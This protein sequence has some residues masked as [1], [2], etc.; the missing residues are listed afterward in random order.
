MKPALNFMI[1]VEADAL[2]A[3]LQRI[4]PRWSR[5]LDFLA[6]LNL[7][8]RSNVSGF[9]IRPS[10]VKP[11]NSYGFIAMSRTCRVYL[12]S[13]GLARAMMATSSSSVM[14]MARLNVPGVRDLLEV[15][16]CIGPSRPLR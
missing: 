16:K 6:Q 11:L 9:S 7:A 4:S 3:A 1:L 15:R 8:C 10:H 5:C 14:S 13:V 2:R 12:T